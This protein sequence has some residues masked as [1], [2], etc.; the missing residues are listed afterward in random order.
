MH[1]DAASEPAGWSLLAQVA[2]ARR[3]RL[4]INRSQMP[5]RNGPASNTVQSIENQT[6]AG[7]ITVRSLRKLD[8]GLLWPT[9]TAECLVH[10][11]IPEVARDW[12]NFVSLCISDT[13][14]RPDET[15]IDRL[16]RNKITA[17]SD[18]I[19]QVNSYLIF[20]DY[21]LASLEKSLEE[22]AT[23]TQAQDIR[24]LKVSLQDARAVVFGWLKSAR[25]DS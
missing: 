12:A 14:D 6:A 24:I 17:M 22:A 7:E 25:E 8:T 13:E 18:Q 10:A 1:T 11:N 19:E 4:G 5:S 23:D 16:N 9:G 21:H 20:M 2:L 3:K 15:I